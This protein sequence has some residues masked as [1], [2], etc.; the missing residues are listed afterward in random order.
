VR[1]LGESDDWR[2]IGKAMGTGTLLKY[3]GKM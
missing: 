2:K 1:Y 3:N